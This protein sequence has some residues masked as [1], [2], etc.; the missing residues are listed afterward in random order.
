MSPGCSTM[1]LWAHDDAL[2]LARGL[3]AGLDLTNS[4]T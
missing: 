1:H 4:K 2:K 3:R